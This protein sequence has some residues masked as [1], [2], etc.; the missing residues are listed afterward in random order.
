MT[1]DHLNIDLQTKINYDSKTLN[2]LEG[3][4]K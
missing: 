3:L 1:N 2:L 4:E